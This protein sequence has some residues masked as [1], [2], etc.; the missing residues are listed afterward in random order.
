MSKI[1][2][3]GF[4]HCGTTILRS[5][6]GHVEEIEE[7][8][9]E[10]ETIHHNNSKKIKMCK[11]PFTLDDFFTKKYEDY[12][13]IF[14]IRNPLYVFSSLNKRFN[15]NIPEDHSLQRYIKTIEKFNHF[16]NSKEKNVYTIKYEDLFD[17]DYEKLK[18][19]LDLIGVKYTSDIF[20]N[21]KYKNIFFTRHNI[22]NKKPSVKNNI[23]YRTWQINQPFVSNNI[24]SKLDLKD[25]QKKN[26][27]NN[28]HIL[29][30]YPKLQEDLGN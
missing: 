27:I 20:D 1:I 9:G 13:K 24:L 6:L 14:I 15:Y 16:E 17:N 10:I 29:K 12:I 4:P 26:I 18:N 5:I 21:S 7:C 25:D 22:P 2:I 3:F 19:I 11:F 23:E 30:V 28:E 8:M